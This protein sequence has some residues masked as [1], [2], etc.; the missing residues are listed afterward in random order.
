MIEVIQS[1]RELQKNYS[2]YIKKLD[3]EKHI[4]VANGRKLNANFFV[5]EPEYYIDLHKQAGREEEAKSLSSTMEEF[6]QK[7][8]V[9]YSKWGRVGGLKK[10]AKND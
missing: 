3:V 4:Y 8:R 7:V 1:M 2:S 6:I 5:V 10:G 9:M